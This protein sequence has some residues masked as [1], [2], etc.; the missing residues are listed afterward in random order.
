M[1]A[2]SRPLIALALQCIIDDP[3]VVEEYI[4]HYIHD[5]DVVDKYVPIVL[6][7]TFNLPSIPSAKET[8]TH[9]KLIWAHHAEWFEWLGGYR[10]RMNSPGSEPWLHVYQGPD[11]ETQVAVQ[12]PSEQKALFMDMRKR[13]MKL[14]C[15][16]FG[17]FGPVDNVRCIYHLHKINPPGWFI[18]K[19]RENILEKNSMY[20][21]CHS[22]AVV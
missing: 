4:R 2:L 15:I 22:C 20:D 14:S 1:D 19:F 8:L 11:T 5:G 18:E 7:D 6:R 21:V 9:L 13:G 10:L 3:D 12:D 16:K 17:V